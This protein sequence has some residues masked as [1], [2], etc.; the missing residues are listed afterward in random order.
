MTVRESVL[1]RVTP[2]GRERRELARTA[3]ELMEAVREEADRV[4]VEAEPQHVGSSSR[5]TWLAGDRDIDV[6]VKLPTSLEREEFVDIGME[7]A[8]AV[9]DRGDEWEE[10]YAEHPYVKARFGEFDVDIVPCFDVEAPRDI[11]SAVDR[12]P[13]HDRYVDDR[14]GELRE[15][16]LLLK[17][18]MKGAGVY[19]AEARVQGFSGYLT[20][21]LVMEF[22]GF[23]G[24]I[25]AAS[26]WR[27]GVSLDPEGHGTGDRFDESL[28]VVDPV[29]PERN[30]AAAL[31]LQRFAEFVR[32]CGDFLEEEREAFFFPPEK[33]PLKSFRSRGTFLAAVEI[34]IS[35]LVEDN[36]YPQLRKTRDALTSGL[37]REG[38]RVLRSEVFP[39]LVVIELFSG[40]VPAVEKHRG[41]PVWVKRHAD[42]FVEKYEGA[43]HFAGPW[44]DEEGRLAVERPRRFTDAEDALNHLVEERKGFGKTLAREAEFEVFTGKRA[45][46]RVPKEFLVRDMPWRREQ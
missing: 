24:V 3:D 39:D 5:G 14:I 37:E 38:F 45:R 35:G 20:E 18:F 42:A 7:I 28:V 33:E 40:E 30:V 36:L 11:R 13:F 27:P 12:T 6:F 43:A 34:S 19:S 15:D 25:E 9:A 23:G 16:V 41:P 29:D 22:G 26:G 4:G 8:R 1:E 17:Q 10:S 44:V 21:L 31:S 32:A 2:G 46:K